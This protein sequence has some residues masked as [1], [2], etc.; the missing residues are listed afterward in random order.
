VEIFL[1]GTSH[2]VASAR[3]RERMHVDVDEMYTALAPLCDARGL[4]REAVPL[5][6]CGRLELYGVA[7]D[8][9]RAVRLL[10]HLMVQRTG[11]DRE[12]LGRHSYVYRDSEAVRHL[13]RVASGLDSVIHG[14]AQILGQVRAAAHH[15]RV[16]DTA[17]PVLHRLFQRALRT[18]KRVRSET[19]IGRGAA[20]LAS[21]SVAMLQREIGGLGEV[22]ALVLGAGDTGALMARLLVKAGIGRLLVANRTLATAEELARELGV[23]A[24]D[25]GSIGSALSG[26]DLVVGAVAT[27]EPLVTPEMIRDM[28]AE[29][30]PSYFLDLAHPRNFD[31]GLAELPGTTVFDLEHVFRRVEAAREAR[32]AHLPRARLVIDEEVRAY[33]TWYRSRENAAVV[34]AV[35]RRMLDRAMIE[36]ERYASR[37][38]EEQKEQMRRLAR[39][40]ARAIL[41][42]PTVV[43][44]D[45]DPSSERGRALLEHASKLFGVDEPTDEERPDPT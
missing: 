43:L 19:G 22:S 38:P 23:E 6:T 12:E 14:E 33:E 7:P 39:S 11:I 32:A 44:R 1:V 10:G 40:V 42:Q 34:E 30:R 31:P 18:G 27:D 25:L 24:C 45:V 8:A 26:A 5:A 2:A 9:D 16:R 21:A 35:R 37:A 15:P 29:R 17:G 20:S 41:H 13:L 3:M 4:L 28:P 36:A